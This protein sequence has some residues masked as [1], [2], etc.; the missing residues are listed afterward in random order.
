M[1]FDCFFVMER[2]SDVT[3]HGLRIVFACGAFVE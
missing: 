2:W 3:E 1:I